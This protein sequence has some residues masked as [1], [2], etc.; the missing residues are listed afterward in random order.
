[1]SGETTK[2]V[3]LDARRRVL[4]GKL[5]EHDQ[6]RASVDGQGVITLTPL[7][8]VPAEPLPCGHTGEP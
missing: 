2:V 6:Y 7:K 1:M 5:A 8:L 4:L 3:R